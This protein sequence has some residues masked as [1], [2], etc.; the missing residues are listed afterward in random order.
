MSPKTHICL[1]L[2]L[3]IKNLVYLYRQERLLVREELSR[4]MYPLSMVLLGAWRDLKSSG[5]V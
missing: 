2:C 1:G 3:I 4:A 5:K